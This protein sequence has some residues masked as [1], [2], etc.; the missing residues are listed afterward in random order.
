MSTKFLVCPPM[1]T[2]VEQDLLDRYTRASIKYFSSKNNI[3]Q[4]KI[5]SNWWT[6]DD[7][8]EF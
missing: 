1:W 5:M 7:S 8:H 2:D 4:L 3:I 6:K